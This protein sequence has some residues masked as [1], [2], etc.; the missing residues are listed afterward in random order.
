MIT[1]LHELSIHPTC[2]DIHSIAFVIHRVFFWL[3]WLRL[4]PIEKSLRFP[5]ILCE[6]GPQ[7]EEVQ[8][9]SQWVLF[10]CTKRVYRGRKMILGFFFEPCH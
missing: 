7:T 6:A 8:S 4:G 10:L 5:N 3:E 2:F 9:F 1:I